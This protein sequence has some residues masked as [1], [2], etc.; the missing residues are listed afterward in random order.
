MEV[1]PYP[2]YNDGE[3]N[4][5]MCLWATFSG[6][7]WA[8]DTISQN[9]QWQVEGL[10]EDAKNLALISEAAAIDGNLD[11]FAASRTALGV[12]SPYVVVEELEVVV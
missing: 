3:I 9:I 1:V 10:V 11:P 4:V 5:N 2:I 12:M 6:G 8:F 7:N